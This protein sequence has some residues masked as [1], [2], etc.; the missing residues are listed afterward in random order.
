MKFGGTSVATL[1]RWQNIRELVAS[2]RAEG[3][4]VLVVVSALTGITDALKQLC[5]EGEPDKRKA[6]AGAIAQR[7]YDLLDHMQLALP[8]TLGS[9]LSDLAGLAANGPA[10]R[11]ELAWQAQVQAHG[12]LMSSALGAAFLSHSGLSTQWLDARECLAAVALPNQNERTRLLSAMVE[13]KP[14]PALNAR[15]AV[16]GEVFITQGFI[17]REQHGRTVLLGRGGSDTSAA[18]FGALLKAARVEIWTDVAGMFTANPRQVPGARLLQRLDYEEAQEIASTGAKVLHPRCLSPLR[19][20]RVPLLVKDTNRPELDGTVIGPEVRAYAPS[21]KAISARKGITLVSMESVGMW[22]QVGFLADVFAQFKQHG[23]SVDLIGS[24]ETNVTVSLDPTE[25]LLDSDAIAAL[26]S[27][28]AKVCRVKVIAPCAAITLVGR[29]MRS[30]LHTLSGVLAEFGQLRVHLITQSSNNLNLTF[31]VDEEVVDQLL[32]HLHDLLIAAGA[33]RTDE[34]ALFG[35]SWQAL[36]GG[37]EVPDVAPAWWR[38]PQR[39][40]LLKLAAEATPRYVYHLPTV[41]RQAREL[42]SLAAVDRLHYAVKANT[43]PAILTALAAEGFAFECVSPGELEAVAAIV[44]EPVPLL[45]TPNFAP[46]RDYV[47]ALATRAT[48]TLDALH[49]LERWGELFRGRE[50]VLRVDLGRGLGHHEKVRTGGSGSKFGLPL[51][52]LPTFLQLADAH[53]VTVRGLHAHLGSGV[54]DAGHWG[55]VYAQLASLAERIG[56]V[57]FLNIGG[58]LGVPSHPGEA[59]LD[60]AELDRVLRE[61]K[62]AYPHYQL[63]MEPG[64]YLVADAGVLLARATQQKGKGA[65]RYLGIDTGMNSLIRPALYDAWHEIINLSRLDEPATALY[66]VVGPICESGDVLGTD[67]RLPEA[68]EDDVILIAQAG[69]YGKVM[70][71]HYNLRDEADEIIIE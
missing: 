10:P 9:R 5:G 55:E 7:H 41:R 66:Q 19:D 44:P 17:A 23:L 28:L 67:R 37:G 14:D 26:A 27:D 32:P 31:V 51:D 1:P 22:Q 34:S 15:L 6:A 35:P 58:G 48:V 38:G 61:V 13:A 47:Y 52:Q 12:E 70:S 2:R 42:K 71:S 18:Y 8:D 68:Q 11:G 3:A 63:W 24:A 69:A 29:G 43:H 53:G 65:F 21:V 50:I 16:L 49:P 46:R 33:L 40:R 57:A 56:S 54:L 20:P 39:Q 25:N 45:F 60:M 36:Y 64:R 30:L 59:R 4:R 62:A